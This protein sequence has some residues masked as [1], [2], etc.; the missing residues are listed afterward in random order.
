MKSALLFAVWTGL[1]WIASGAVYGY[2]LHLPDANVYRLSKT[3]GSRPGELLVECLN[4]ADATVRPM[5][6]FGR[7]V[8]SC[9]ETGQVQP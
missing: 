4:G 9:G 1:V 8:V 6:E 2:D 3:E 7:I 5:P